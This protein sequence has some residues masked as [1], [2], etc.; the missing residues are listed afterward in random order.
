MESVTSAACLLQLPAV[1]EA[2]CSFFAR[3]LHPS[4]CI[5]IRLFA[6]MLDKLLV[7]VNVLPCFMI[8]DAQSCTQ[9][10]D[11]ARQYTEDHFL[12]VIHNQVRGQ[13]DTLGRRNWKNI[14]LFLCE[15]MYL[16]SSS[17]C[18]PLNLPSCSPLMT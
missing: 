5:G 3:L 14:K 15:I 9:L 1:V 16:R 17:C 8:S 18:L 12:E 6:G 10:R 2:C 7:L 11:T 13:G 4:N